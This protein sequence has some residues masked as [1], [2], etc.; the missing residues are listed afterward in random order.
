MMLTAAGRFCSLE[1]VKPRGFG[2]R[3]RIEPALGFNETDN[4]I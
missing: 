1:A 3:R 4:A 2:L